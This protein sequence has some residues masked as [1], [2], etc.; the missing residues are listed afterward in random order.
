MT[1]LAKG[2][3]AAVGGTEERR[4]LLD[5]QLVGG[6]TVIVP[7]RTE[8][9]ELGEFIGGEAV[10]REPSRDISVTRWV[11]Q[12]IEP[13]AT[14][15][16]SGVWGGSVGCCRRSRWSWDGGCWRGS[17]NARARQD[18]RGWVRCWQRSGSD[19]RNGR[20]WPRARGSQG[21]GGGRACWG[22]E[23]PSKFPVVQVVETSSDGIGV[24]GTGSKFRKRSQGRRVSL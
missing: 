18:G 19:R 24:W 23:P 4:G 21:G 22:A 10:G 15:I 2:A 5:L 9:F 1:T 3:L 8:G 20:R 12:A 7:S 11:C 6:F 13:D 17:G 14:L 16:L